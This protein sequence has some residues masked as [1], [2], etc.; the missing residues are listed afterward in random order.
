MDQSLDIFHPFPRLPLELRDK[1]WKDS[2]PISKTTEG[3]VAR[4]V[5]RVKAYWS[6][7]ASTQ[8]TELA[9]LR[10]G[11]RY[12]PRKSLHPAYTIE[13]SR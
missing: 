9:R 11:H 10:L 2:L 1:I 12:E 6:R 5:I 3:E 4:R 8:T 7:S 13:L